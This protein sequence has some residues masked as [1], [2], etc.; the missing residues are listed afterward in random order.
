MKEVVKRESSS[1]FRLR[2]LGHP[3]E[4]EMSQCAYIAVK[5]YILIY[6]RGF[7][8]EILYFRTYIRICLHRC[9]YAITSCNL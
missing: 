8:Q 3:L 9:H 6:L 5:I 7:R 1:V 4:A 2:V